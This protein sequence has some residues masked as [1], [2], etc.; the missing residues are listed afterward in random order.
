MARATVYLL[1]SERDPSRYYTG[2]TTDPVRRLAQHNEGLS[3]HT[4]DGRPWRV[5]VSIEFA[6]A[7]KAATFETYLKSGSGRAFARRHFR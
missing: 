2:F 4:S 6:D 1:Q 3:A 7:K 5:I